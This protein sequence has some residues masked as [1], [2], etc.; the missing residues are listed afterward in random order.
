MAQSAKRPENTAYPF[1]CETSDSVDGDKRTIRFWTPEPQHEPPDWRPFCPLALAAE[2]VS[3]VNRSF[4]SGRLPARQ[5]VRA[6]LQVAGST[7]A[8]LPSTAELN[9]SLSP[10][11]GAPKCSSC[12]NTGSGS[13]VTKA[14]PQSISSGRRLAWASAAAVNILAAPEAQSPNFA[15][16]EA[17]PVADRRRVK[18][19][20]SMK[21][22]ESK[23][24]AV[25]LGRAC[26]FPPLSSGGALVAQP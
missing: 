20:S 6:A 25:T 11:L 19:S 26:L 8:R 7:F 3:N 4:A 9:A 16:S 21:S 13:R 22:V 1:R 18:R 24:G 17:A 14:S 2:V 12:C 5:A 23:C 10:R 15:S